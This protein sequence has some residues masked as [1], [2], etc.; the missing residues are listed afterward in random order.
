MTKKQLAKQLANE[1]NL[2]QIDSYEYA[3]KLFS[4]IA[5]EL[6]NGNK[7]EISDFGVFKPITTK[8][9]TGFNPITKEKIEI[10][11]KNTVKFKVSKKLIKTVK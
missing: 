8:S 11:A 6:E 3:T 10:P 9:R 5:E 2:K 4:L 1:L 7:V